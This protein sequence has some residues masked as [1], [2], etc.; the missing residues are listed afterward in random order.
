MKSENY[1]LKHTNVRIALTLKEKEQAKFLAKSQGFTFQGWL[2][3]IVRENYIKIMSKKIKR[4][5]MIQN[6]DNSQIYTVPFRKK[7]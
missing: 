3:N 1:Y 2:G 7:L 4:K 5:I 6:K